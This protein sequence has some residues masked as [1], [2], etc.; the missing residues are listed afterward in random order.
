M[1][2]GPASYKEGAVAAVVVVA[3]AVD[4][5]GRG[6]GGGRKRRMGGRGEGVGEGRGGHSG[7]KINLLGS[8]HPRCRSSKLLNCLQFRR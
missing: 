7:R 8:A 6:S 3:V 2:R 5:L 1:A 4:D